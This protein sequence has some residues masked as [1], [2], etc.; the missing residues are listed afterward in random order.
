[1][2][3]LHIVLVLLLS[4]E[5]RNNSLTLGKEELMNY[6][7]NLKPYAQENRK[8]GTK[9][10]AVLWKKVFRAKNTGYSFNRQ[11][12]IGNYIVDFICRELNLIIEIDGNSHERKE[13]ASKD[14]DKQYFLESQG[15][16]VVRFSESE[17]LKRLDSVAADIYNAISS[18]E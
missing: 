12:I 8:A 18:L 1:M 7:G 5:D 4:K 9:A 2:N 17:V 6:N 3:M 13:V 11:F 16:T 14:S 10:E 15:Y